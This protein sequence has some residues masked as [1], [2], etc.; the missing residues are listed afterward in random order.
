MAI[1]GNQPPATP[2]CRAVRRQLG[3]DKPPVDVG[4]HLER[5]DGCRAEARRL[6]AAWALLNV[7]E[8]LQPSPQFSQ[9]V[10]AK[11]AVKHPSTASRIWGGGLPVW[12]WRWA[13]GGLAVILVAVVPVAVWYQDRHDRPEL[14]AQ[15][16]LVESRELLTNLDVVQDLDVLLLLDD[17]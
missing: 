14:V 11:I 12:S 6:R 8:P 9:R 15:L 16:D 10:W 1:D 2:E 5:C 3:V 13:A 17:P 4:L 7:V